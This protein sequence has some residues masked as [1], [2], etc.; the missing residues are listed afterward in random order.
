MLP[1]LRSLKLGDDIASIAGAYEQAPMGCPDPPGAATITTDGVKRVRDE[2]VSIVNRAQ[3]KLGRF[4]M[5]Y[6]LLVKDIIAGVDTPT[7]EPGLQFFAL[8]ELQKLLSGSLPHLVFEP[9]NEARYMSVS[10]TRVTD[11]MASRIAL[12][13]FESKTEAPPPAPASSSV[14]YDAWRR[15]QAQAVVDRLST[16]APEEL[17]PLDKME[18]KDALKYLAKVVVDNSENISAWFVRNNYDLIRTF[19]YNAVDS[20]LRLP[21]SK[22]RPLLNASVQIVLQ[23]VDGEKY[24]PLADFIHMDGEQDFSKNGSRYGRP[25]A[26]QDVSSLVTSFCADLVSPGQIALNACSTVYF[27]NT[28]VVNP[29]LLVDAARKVQKYPGMGVHT[30][31]EIISVMGIALDAATSNA[32][33]KRSE[34]ELFKIGIVPHAVNMLEWSNANALAFHRSALRDEV[35]AGAVAAADGGVAPR[36]RAFAILR[37]DIREEAIDAIDTIRLPNLIRM[38]RE[39]EVRAVVTVLKGGRGAG[40]GEDAMP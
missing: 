34:D 24:E 1:S 14:S 35:L 15:S 27:A 28:P 6:E 33:K 23:F 29:E 4:S 16:K 8:Q 22:S 7:G 25:A 32:L 5:D 19:A 2:V 9:S 37:T 13:F 36:M 26:E 11:E 39:V 17:T 12:A 21:N 40:M 20:F 18:L 30:E 10:D 3:L 38:D 31:Y